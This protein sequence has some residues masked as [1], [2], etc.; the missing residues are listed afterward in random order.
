MLTALTIHQPHAGLIRLRIKRFETRGWGTTFRG[1][2]AIHAGKMFDDEFWR[3]ACAGGWIDLDVDRP[4]PECTVR[5]AIV[6]VADVV[7]SRRM[8]EDDEEQ[9]VSSWER[10]KF[11][12]DL[13]NVRP[14]EPPV[15]CRGQQGLWTVPPDVEAAVRAELWQEE[16]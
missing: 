13:Q 16:K 12:L 10:G 8:T 1:P 9:A 14:V 7:D 5:G 2:L 4:P 11:V 6:A 15:T 3:E